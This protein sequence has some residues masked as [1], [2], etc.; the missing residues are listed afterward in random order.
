MERDVVD[1]K[2]KE[3]G[4]GE[5]FKYWRLGRSDCAKSSNGD[6]TTPIHG[7]SA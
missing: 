7:I 6:G 2:R 1:S 4:K 3:G 5:G